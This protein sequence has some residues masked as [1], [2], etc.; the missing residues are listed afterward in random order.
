MIWFSWYF[1]N[2][3]WGQMKR[4][5][6]QKIKWRKTASHKISVL[7]SPSQKSL[8]IL[9]E[10]FSYQQTTKRIAVLILLIV[11][12]IAIF[13][14]SC[15]FGSRSFLLRAL[16]RV[17]ARHSP[18]PNGKYKTHCVPYH[19]AQAVW[20]GILMNINRCLSDWQSGTTTRFASTQRK[21]G[22]FSTSPARTALLFIARQCINFRCKIARFAFYSWSKQLR[23]LRLLLIHLLLSLYFIA[24][25][26]TWQKKCHTMS[27]Y[28]NE[29]IIDWWLELITDALTE[30]KVSNLYAKFNDDLAVQ[31]N[32]I[33]I[34]WPGERQKIKEIDVNKSLVTPPHP[35]FNQR[36][37]RNRRE[38][39]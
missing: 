36:N 26:I 4:Q 10:K 28:P 29:Y 15:V 8:H 30:K 14:L 23:L 38:Q 33:H 27:P 16:E 13:R 24:V 6:Q 9:S 25:V 11:A 34:K 12:S 3:S 17:L 32:Q 22:E 19:S 35:L 5:Q 2:F 1:I 39:R 18:K 21:K 37:R 7:L 31:I 20:E